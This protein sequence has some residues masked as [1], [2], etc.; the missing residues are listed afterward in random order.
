LS[1]HYSEVIKVDGQQQDRVSA[2]MRYLLAENTGVPLRIEKGKK[3]ICRTMSPQQLAE[4]ENR[5]AEWLKSTKKR[6]A[7]PGPEHA[8]QTIRAA[9]D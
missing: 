4:A 1:E 6:S 3:D 9:G 5:A 8:H 2:Y 7:F